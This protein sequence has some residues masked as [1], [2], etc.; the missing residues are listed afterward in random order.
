MRRGVTDADGSGES[1][2]GH[3]A[4]SPVSLECPL[5]FARGVSARSA[6]SSARDN[7]RWSIATRRR[8]VVRNRHRA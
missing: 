6:G 4:S 1:D 3:Y 7:S 8:A 5:V 2:V